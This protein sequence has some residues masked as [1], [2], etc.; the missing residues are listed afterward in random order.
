MSRASRALF[1]YSLLAAGLFFWFW[2]ST[3][4]QAKNPDV[5]SDC[6]QWTIHGFPSDRKFGDGRTDSY[7]HRLQNQPLMGVKGPIEPFPDFSEFIS[8]RKNIVDLGSG[9]SDFIP[10]LL[11]KCVAA[12]GMCSGLHA[13]DQSYSKIKAQVQDAPHFFT[14]GV[15][16]SIARYPA[17]FHGQLFQELDIRVEGERVLFDQAVSS[18]SLI[19]VL[20]AAALPECEIIFSRILDHMARRGHLRFWKDGHGDLPAVF[21]KIEPYLNRLLS[22]GEISNYSTLSEDIDVFVLVK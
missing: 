22:A 6:R 14:R 13:V 20:K 1:L 10:T 7:A 5:S 11:D 21:Q 4:V 3:E 16:S 9:E 12:G 18:S 2:T 17:N 8:G 15:T 19:Y